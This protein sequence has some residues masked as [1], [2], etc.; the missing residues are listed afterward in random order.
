[1]NQHCNHDI[2]SE[3]EIIAHTKNCIPEHEQIKEIELATK[4]KT[5]PAAK[6][7]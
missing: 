4:Q 7:K 3:D 2:V 6:T 5:Q 1:M